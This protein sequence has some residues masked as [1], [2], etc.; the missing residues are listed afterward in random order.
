MAPQQGGNPMAPHIVD[1]L[2]ED[3]HQIPR[4]AP[5]R[6]EYNP[7][8]GHTGSRDEGDEE[9]QKPIDTKDEL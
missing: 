2:K 5:P 1:K 8:D 9:D 6:D 7:S 3:R 4:D